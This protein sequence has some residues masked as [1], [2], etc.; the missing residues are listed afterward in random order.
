MAGSVANGIKRDTV[1]VL[2]RARQLLGERFRLQQL[3]LL[4]D[5]ARSLGTGASLSYPAIWWTGF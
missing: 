3:Q 1:I 5:P 4:P 2:G